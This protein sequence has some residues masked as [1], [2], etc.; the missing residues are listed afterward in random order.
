MTTK[1]TAI[2]L[3][4][5]GT[6]DA[7]TPTAVRSYLREFLSDTRVI[8]IP[9]LIWQVILNCFVLTTRPKR[10][11]EAYDSVWTAEGSPLLAILKQQAQDLQTQ[12]GH[13]GIHTPVYAA[14]T[15]G[16]PSI[17]S[18]MSQL[19][20]EGVESFVVLPLFPQYSATSTAAAFDKIFQLMLA[21]RNLPQLHM[22]KDY[23]NHPLYIEALAQSVERYWQANGRADK[24]LMSFH[25]IPKPYADK[26]DPYPEQCRATA[27]LLADRLGLAADAWAVSFQSRFGAQEWLKPY[28]D[29]LL[30]EWG[31]AG[32]SV[33]VMSPAFSADC[34][35]TLEELAVENRD[36]FLQAGGKSYDYIPAL[37]TDPLHIQ[38]MASLIK[39]YLIE[40]TDSL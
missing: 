18:V 6:P 2:I 12:L 4:N 28:T 36:H 23:H 24:L 25:G 11:A 22:I 21:T 30:A 17:K 1:K 15:Y 14:T 8:E 13:H 31:R 10:V 37:N 34:L 19:M 32:L 35:E 3:A 16:N 29:E 9:K 27:V 40:H 33:Q 5:L 38:M 7:P 39:P 20:A 26:G